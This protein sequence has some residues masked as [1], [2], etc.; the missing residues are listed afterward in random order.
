MPRSRPRSWRDARPDLVSRAGRTLRRDSSPPTKRCRAAHAAALAEAALVVAD[1][2]REVYASAKRARGV[3]D[4][5]D[6]IAETLQLLE[7]RDA[8]AWVLY[9]LDGGI[10]QS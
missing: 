6:L 7:R 5:D 2:V 8:A 10:D 1:A 9:K 3:L 4:Y